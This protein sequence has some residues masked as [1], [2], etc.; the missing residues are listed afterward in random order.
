L[1]RSTSRAL[2]DAS[3]WVGAVA[4]ATGMT[5]VRQASSR[6]AR[7]A[8]DFTRQ[9]ALWDAPG[10]PCRQWTEYKGAARLRRERTCAAGP[11]AAGPWPAESPRRRPPGVADRSRGSRATG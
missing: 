8:M 7:D 5:R 4:W 10:A 11:D 9:S 2:P 6:P 1:L 3:S